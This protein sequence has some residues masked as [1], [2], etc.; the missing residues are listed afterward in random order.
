VPARRI[1]ADCGFEPEGDA[2]HWRSS[3]DIVP[4][5]GPPAWLTINE[6]A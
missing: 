5:A 3:L 6:Y 4:A 1:Y 2:R